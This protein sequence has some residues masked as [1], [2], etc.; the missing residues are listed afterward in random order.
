MNVEPGAA[1]LSAT[2]A[3]C[4]RPVNGKEPIR[5]H[6][7]PATARRTITSAA[8]VHRGDENVVP[9]GPPGIGYI[10]NT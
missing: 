6:S 8:T 4:T 1:R 3:A 5:R 2:A 9:L 10:G 7:L